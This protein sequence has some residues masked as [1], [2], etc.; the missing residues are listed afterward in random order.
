M[1][2]PGNKDDVILYVTDIAGNRIDREWVNDRD[3]LL[4]GMLGA[5]PGADVSSDAF[6]SFVARWRAQVPRTLYGAAEGD[7]DEE[8]TDDDGNLIYAQTPPGASNRNCIGLNY[9]AFNSDGGDI[10]SCK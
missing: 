9:T 3:T 7:C 2:A 1:S 5:V 6:L 8:E 4:T 10:N